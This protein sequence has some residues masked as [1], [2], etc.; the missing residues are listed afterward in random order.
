MLIEAGLTPMDAIQA[1]TGVASRIL[2]MEDSFGTIAKG[3]VADLI[4]L[5]GNPLDDPMALDRVTHVIQAGEL[6]KQPGA[7]VPINL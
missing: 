3:K 2:H 4:V 5:D 1:S 6:I 7:P